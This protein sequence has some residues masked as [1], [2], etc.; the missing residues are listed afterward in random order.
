M[1]DRVD[2]VIVGAGPAGMTAAI[3]ARELGAKSVVVLDEQTSA[4]GQIWR[5]IEHASRKISTILGPDY[6]AGA[7]VASA[8]RKANVDHIDGAMVWNITQDKVLNYVRHGK[9]YELHAKTVL[10]CT[11]AQERPFPIPG[12]TL[13]GVMTAGAAQVLLKGNGVA[14][15]QPPV[16]IGCGPL[17]YLLCWQY[18][19]AGI[20]VGAILDTT[21]ARDYLQ[22]I[23][24]LGSAI[25]GWRYLK[26][27]IALISEI[28]KEKIP[29]HRGVRDLKLSGD[30]HVSSV[31][32]QCRG[33]TERI[34]TNLVFLHQGVV[35]N[36]QFTW[37]L[38]AKHR[39]SEKQLCWIPDVDETGQ[40][41]GIEGIYVA[42]DGRGIVGANAAV[43]QGELAAVSALTKL[44]ILS[45]RKGD[46]A[47]M[48]IRK[49][50]SRE[51]AVRPFLETVY[52]PQ[53]EN[54]IPVSDSVTVCRCEEL[55]AGEI[56]Q[57]VAEGCQGPNQA[58]S[59]GRCG[60]G[61][62]QGRMCGLTVTELMARELGCSP[63]GVGY[64]RIRAPIKPI[65][66]AELATIE[67]FPSS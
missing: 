2:V 43:Y 41:I 45:R 64:Y 51:V 38:R 62:C 37:A 36:T 32:F 53:D 3:K 33:T 66:L 49:K 47:I 22:A 67:E 63:T 65:T 4:G 40:L 21:S 39:W 27:G 20:R 29:F 57:F 34:D 48:H 15:A 61:P 19:R 42:G 18:L 26:K 25:R 6:V 54:R 11:G 16:L 7:K 1:S 13:P 5:N 23:P 59:F 44:G 8:F 9:S 24:D 55:K 28:K 12:W 56:R 35:P 30:S 60:M 31:E 50:L 10:L 52:K 58:K 17:L 14:A 46:D